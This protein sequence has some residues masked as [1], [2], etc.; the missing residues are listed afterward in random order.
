MPKFNM[1][2]VYFY[3]YSANFKKERKNRF[4]KKQLRGLKK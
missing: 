2:N 3:K 1:I 4:M